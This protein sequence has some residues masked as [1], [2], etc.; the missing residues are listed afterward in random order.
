MHKV[1]WEHV[2]FPEDELL[3]KCE[4]CGKMGSR[5]AHVLNH[6]ESTHFPYTFDYSCDIC[7][8]KMKTK[9]SLENHVYHNHKDG[10]T[11]IIVETQNV[12]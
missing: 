5:K 8:K 1:N 9:K 3:F 10:Q 2:E 4:I 12:N 7:K 11:D 6:V